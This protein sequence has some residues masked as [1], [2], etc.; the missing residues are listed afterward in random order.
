[1]PLFLLINFEQLSELTFPLNFCKNEFIY[2]SRDLFL[3][4]KKFGQGCRCEF[5]HPKEFFVLHKTWN[6]VWVGEQVSV[7]VDFFHGF[8][9]LVIQSGVS[10]R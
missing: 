5:I 6:F 1:M 8:T 3:Y 9:F 4:I 2:L 7:G 10:H